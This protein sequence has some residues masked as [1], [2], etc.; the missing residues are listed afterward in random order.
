MFT[1]TLKLIYARELC[2]LPFTGFADYDPS[3]CSKKN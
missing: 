2:I 1:F 3:H